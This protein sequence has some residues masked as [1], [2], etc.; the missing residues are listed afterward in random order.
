MHDSDHFGPTRQI[1]WAFFFAMRLEAKPFVKNLRLIRKLDDSPCPVHLHMAGR[2]QALIV[3]TGIGA[4]R[5]TSAI[6]WV[7]DRFDPQ[8]V[9]VG[10]FAGALAPNLAIGDVF[11][12]SEVVEPS[13]DIRW[14]TAIPAELGDLPCGRLVTV[15]KLVAKAKDKRSLARQTKAIGVDMESAAIAE[16]CVEQHIPCA[17]I[18]VISDEM[19]DELS[20]RLAELFSGGRVSIARVARLLLRSPSSAIELWRLA[21]NSR[22]A[23]RTLAA[24][25]SRLIA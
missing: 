25:L 5:A 4:I 20:P 6:R 11:V 1:G 17:I 14:R 24:A 18:R 10:G 12:A 23:S 19:D 15:P 3:E 8:L 13:D 7:L 22:R 16:T 2:S 21:R 9:V